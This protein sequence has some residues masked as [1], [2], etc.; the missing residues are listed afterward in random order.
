MNRIIRIFCAI[1]LSGSFVIASAQDDDLAKRVDRQV[2]RLDSIASTLFMDEKYEE[3]LDKLLL[4]TKMLEP[5]PSDPRYVQALLK[6]GLCYEQLNIPFKAIEVNKRAITLYKNQHEDDVFVANRSNTIATLYLKMD[7]KASAQQWVEETLRISDQI[8]PADNDRVRYLTTA[9]QTFFALENH[10]EAIKYQKEIIGLTGKYI[11]HHHDDYLELLSTLRAYYS[12]AGQTTLHNEVSAEIKQLKKELEEGIVPEDTDLSTP[13]L[14]RRHNLEALMCSRW[15]L[16]NYLSTPGM[17][18]AAD[19]I[20]KFRKRTPD[21]AVYIGPAEDWVKKNA[22]YYVA[23][24]AASVEYA[25][26][27]PDEQRYSLEQ[28]K[29][30]MYRLLAYYKEN[31]NSAGEIKRFDSYLDLQ[32]KKPT[33]LE[34][35]LEKNFEAFVDAM[36]SKRGKINV[37]DPVLLNFSY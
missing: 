4:E 29:A 36:N 27:H 30:A 14:C 35:R 21:A 1:I 16:G 26:Q 23:Y 3:A 17:K 18:D 12:G 25:L 32:E 19:F 31:K 28:Y 7:D 11:N 9:A 24:I 13:L 6:M 22:R 33:E 8:K 37:E 15:I 34:K 10:Q 2:I 20:V 5:T